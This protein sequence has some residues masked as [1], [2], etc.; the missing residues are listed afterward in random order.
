MG[1]GLEC[2]LSNAK[3]T[4]SIF[5]KLPKSHMLTQADFVVEML[6]SLTYFQLE[7]FQISF[8]S[9][10]VLITIKPRC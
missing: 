5:Y 4:M 3:T 6:C 9:S 8:H 10:G 7:R 2:V 1:F